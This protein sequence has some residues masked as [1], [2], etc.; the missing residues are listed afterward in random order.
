MRMPALPGQITPLPVTAN[1]VGTGFTD[2]VT[3]A[4]LT[5]PVPAVPVTVYTVA[6][7][8][9]A[10]TTAPVVA[11]SPAEGDHEYVAAPPAVRAAEAP[12]QI[13]KPGPALTAGNVFTNTVI[14]VLLMQPVLLA[15]VTV[16]VVV[17]VGLAETPGPTVLDSPAAGAHVY[18][19][20]PAA[21]KVADEPMQIA[22]PVPPVMTGKGLTVTVTVALLTQ[23]RE[24]VPVTV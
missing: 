17:T 18:V 19:L 20:P 4:L 16:Y 24:L 6:E 10:E 23:P 7:E 5:Q 11:E 3:V 1:I 15:P 14:V 13:A 8:G 2:T 22:A 9:L 21:V 12:L